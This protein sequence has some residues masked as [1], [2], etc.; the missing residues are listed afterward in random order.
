MPDRAY[1][2]GGRSIR[3]SGRDFA[4]RARSGTYGKGCG[5]NDVDITQDTGD[6]GIQ[7]AVTLDGILVG[8]DFHP[9]EKNVRITVFANW[10]EFYQISP[11]PNGQPIHVVVRVPL[12]PGKES[13][14]ADL[15]QSYQHTQAGGL[16]GNLTLLYMALAIFLG[17]PLITLLVW[18]VAK[19]TGW[20]E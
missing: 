9:I 5:A 10:M 12:L 4:R 11:K 7:I 2:R 13:L 6:T 15:Q 8:E 19:V 20:V 3:R 16:S 18:F 17:L 1:S 14:A